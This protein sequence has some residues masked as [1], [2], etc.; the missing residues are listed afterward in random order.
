MK[1]EEYKQAL[2]KIVSE[3]DT[4]AATISDLVD[5]LEEDLTIVEGA[6]QMIA[7]KDAIIEEKQKNIDSLS[8]TILSIRL[9]SLKDETPETK[10]EDEG[11]EETI[12]DELN[13]ILEEKFGEKE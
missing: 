2:S 9:N 7:D 10:E 12:D 3:P 1:L 4:A 6:A 13:R 5:A 11:K 8:K